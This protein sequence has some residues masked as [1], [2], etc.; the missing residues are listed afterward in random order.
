M[1][2]MPL[3]GLMAVGGVYHKIGQ[4]KCRRTETIVAPVKQGQIVFQGKI[5]RFNINMDK[6]RRV[7]LL[8]LKS[9]VNVVPDHF[10]GKV[11]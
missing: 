10:P 3:A 2:V 7:R 11:T 4:I 1:Q 9:V 6:G 5:V 8:D